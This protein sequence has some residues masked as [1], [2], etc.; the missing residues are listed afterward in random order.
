MSTLRGSKQ[1]YLLDDG[2]RPAAHELAAEMN[3]RYITRQG[4]EFFKAGNLNNALCSISEDFV[5][6]VDAEDTTTVREI[7]EMFEQ[8]HQRQ[9]RP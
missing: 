8:Q 2:R 7:R 1:I 3:I 4:N 5:V 6:V 9:A